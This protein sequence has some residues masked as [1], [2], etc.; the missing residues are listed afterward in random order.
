M[1][2]IMRGSVLFL[3]KDQPAELCLGLFPTL[4]ENDRTSRPQYIHRGDPSDA[5]VPYAGVVGLKLRVLPA[6]VCPVAKAKPDNSNMRLRGDASL[7]KGGK[8]EVMAWHLNGAK[9]RHDLPYGSMMPLSLV[10]T[11]FGEENSVL[12]PDARRRQIRNAQMCRPWLFGRTLF[13]SDVS[14]DL[15]LR[16]PDAIGNKSLGTSST[17]DRSGQQQNQPVT[18]GET[19]VGDSRM[20]CEGRDTERPHC[21]RA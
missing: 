16:P 7:V 14:I 12:D 8:Q 10:S 21:A 11:L 1:A 19:R 15:N 5:S 13:D 3:P 9:N 18:C 2:E 17:S 4:V 6:P 20:T